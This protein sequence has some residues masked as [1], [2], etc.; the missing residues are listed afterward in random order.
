MPAPRRPLTPTDDRHGKPAGH[1][2]HRREGTEPCA[3][4]RQARTEYQ[5]EW[6]RTRSTLGL[7][8]S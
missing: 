6:R 1:Q 8:A 7:E 4:C 3:A 5:R 2:A